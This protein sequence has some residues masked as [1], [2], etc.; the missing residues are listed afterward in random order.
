MTK[1]AI[2]QIRGGIGMRKT[3]KDTLKH[4][5]LQRKNSC[6]IVEPSESIKGMIIKTKDYITWGEIDKETLKILIKK[7][8]RIVGNKQL[9]EEYVQ[10]KLKINLD[11]FTDKIYDSKIK[12]RDLPG[13]KT[14]FRLHPP[15]HGF[16][17]EGTKKP[18]SLG[19]SLGYR[20]DKINELIQRMI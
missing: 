7:R 12:L 17:R 5:R 4:L 19:G 18:F 13:F 15:I 20:K 1:V 16:E 6:V 11:E 8:G 10:S 9:T 3:V 2:V 14:F